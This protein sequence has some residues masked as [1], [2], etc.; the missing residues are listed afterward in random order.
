MSPNIVPTTQQTYRQAALVLG[1]A[2]ADE[3]VSMVV[4]RK[5]S[6]ER[7]IRALASDFAGEMVASLRLSYPVHV[8]EDEKVVAAAI[9]YP[10]GSY[11]LPQLD[12]WLI[13]L[14]TVLGNGWYD[15]RSWMKW[16]D[17][18]E[19][20]HPTK[21]HYYLPCIGVDPAYQGKG[22][23][24]AIM[25]H[26]A[27]KADQDGVGC[28]LENANPRNIPFYQRFGF[29]IVNEKEILGFTNWFMWREP[30]RSS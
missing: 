3:P 24:S 7:R 25:A 30:S 11:P 16:L 4:Y 1:K 19:K 21:A 12:Q 18:A 23:G 27:A 20:L 15:I 9:I 26:M 5:F 13:L 17:E 8:V 2:F 14:K 28:Y 22:F 6:P 29:E 10:P